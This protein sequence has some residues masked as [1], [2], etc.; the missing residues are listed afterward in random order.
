MNVTFAETSDVVWQ[1]ECSPFRFSMFFL[2]IADLSFVN[3]GSAAAVSTGCHNE[4]V[5][6]VRC[7]TGDDDD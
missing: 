1:M 4:S 6:G 2:F 3:M 7:V 5:D